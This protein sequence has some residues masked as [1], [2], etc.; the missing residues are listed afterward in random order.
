MKR[1]RRK[2]GSSISIILILLFHWTG[3]R[4]NGLEA[5]SG[6]DISPFQLHDMTG[7]TIALSNYRGS[8]VVV[9]FFATWCRPCREEMDSLQRLVEMTGEGRLTVLAISVAEPAIRV[10]RFFD[11]RPINF[12][13]VLDPDRA[14]ARAW[15]VAT[16]PTSYV[17]DGQLRP[18]FVVRG[19]LHWD[20]QSIAQTLR[21]IGTASQ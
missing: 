1:I 16:L 14:V 5:W 2:V 19:T 6:D 18:K 4:A 12:P 13:V 3:T 10:R 20:D 8:P 21:M 7:S 11:I 17:L 15:R 9:H